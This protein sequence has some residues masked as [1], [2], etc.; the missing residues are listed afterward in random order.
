MRPAWTP[1]RRS[2]SKTIG[3]IA[4]QPT[5]LSKFIKLKNGWNG[6]VQRQQSEIFHVIHEQSITGDHESG[7]S[8][9]LYSGKCLIK[10]VFGACVYNVE[11]H[12]KNAG[13]RLQIPR[14]DWAATLVGLTG[15]AISVAAGKKSCNGC[16]LFGKISE[17]KTVASVILPPGRLRLATTPDFTGSAPMLKTIG[18]VAV[19][20]FA[21]ST[22]GRAHSQRLAR[23]DAQPGRQPTPAAARIALPRNNTRLLNSGPRYSPLGARGTQDSTLLPC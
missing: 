11:I 3:T 20:A 18:M 13:S 16:N 6:V 9:R 4:H 2:A 1:A 19:A 5:C 17:L 8:D 10:I 14:C 23:H 15:T 22:T 12:A 7:R 21:A